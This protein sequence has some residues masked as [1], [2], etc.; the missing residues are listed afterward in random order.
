MHLKYKLFLL[1]V[2]QLMRCGNKNFAFITFRLI[3]FYL[4]QKYPNERDIYRLFV[5]SLLNISPLISMT[6]KK[7]AGKMVKIPVS[8]S[9]RRSFSL[10]IKWLI[11][12]ALVDKVEK[13]LPLNIVH[14]LDLAYEKKGGLL[15]KKND[16][17][18]EVLEARVNIRLLRKKRKKK[19]I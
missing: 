16:Y 3:L 18:L 11:E 8:I 10:G 12:A 4:K 1:F 17:H 6:K 5:Q 14:Q 13:N 2:N 19:K 15:K 9:E 7:V